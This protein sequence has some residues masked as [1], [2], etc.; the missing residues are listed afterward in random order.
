MPFGIAKVSSGSVSWKQSLRSVAWKQ[1]CYAL[2]VSGADVI[3]LPD[4][5]PQT[6]HH[7]QLQTIIIG[8]KSNSKVFTTIISLLL[9]NITIFF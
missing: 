6:H 1:S 3:L 4:Y 8:F 2:K 5:H 7:L 9:I